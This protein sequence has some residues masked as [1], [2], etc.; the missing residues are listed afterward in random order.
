LAIYERKLNMPALQ[1]KL[2]MG[3]NPHR[4]ARR[5]KTGNFRSTNRISNQFHMASKE[6]SVDKSPGSRNYF[7]LCCFY[8]CF[9][10]VH[11]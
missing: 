11:F 3:E 7:Y 9:Q 4:V 10:T 1:K 8:M 6:G 5:E 2:S